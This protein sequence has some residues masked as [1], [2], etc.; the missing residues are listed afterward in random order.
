MSFHSLLDSFPIIFLVALFTALNS[1]ECHETYLILLILAVL[2]ATVE[3][4]PMSLQA[5]THALISRTER[6][7]FY[8]TW[9]EEFQVVGERMC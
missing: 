1:S 7:S 3:D 8:V 5:L 4:R 9:Q 2:L 6:E